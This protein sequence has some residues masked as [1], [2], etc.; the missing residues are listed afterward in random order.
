MKTA[1]KI[2]ASNKKTPAG[3]R[4]IFISALLLFFLSPLGFSQ[5]GNTD[6][7]K[8][9]AIFGDNMVL[10]RDKKVPVWG[11]ASP[12]ENIIVKINGQEKTAKADD[13]GNW[14]VWMEPSKAGGPY[15]MTVSNGKSNIEFK[16]VMYGD[17]WI[18][19]GQSN[20]AMT[21]NKCK[22]S[23]KEIAGANYPEIRSL[24]I[25]RFSSGS[26]DK[27]M[28]SSP[29]LVCSPET[30]SGFSGA[31]YFF[32]RDLYKELKI[33][34]GIINS[35]IGGTPAESWTAV[36]VLEADPDLAP[37][38]ERFKSAVAAYPENKKKFDAETERRK[39]LS[40]D[41]LKKLPKLTPPM[42]IGHLKAPC[43]L[44]NAMIYPLMPYA[45]K[46]AIW[47]QGEANSGRAYQYR[48]LLPAM[49]SDWRKKWGQGNF[50]FLIVQLASYRKPQETPAS[51]SWA[52]L[53]EAQT[54]TL[55][56]PETA[57]ALA[58]DIG[59]ANNIHPENKQG[60]GYRLSLAALKKAYGKDIV[61][62]GPAYKSMTVE[63]DKAR[64]K[65]DHIG[66]GLISKDGDL[67]RFS[68]AGADKNFV[69]ASAKIDGDTVI[70]WNENVKS[71]AAVRYAW[72]T[73]PEGCNLYNKEG[74]PAIPFRTD[75]WPGVTSQ[76][77]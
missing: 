74:L 6:S 12:G 32:A 50:P 67:K 55:S 24:T 8:P 41:E 57:L 39:Q 62:S 38:L 68:I 63:G 1:S 64:V 43:G 11:S 75:D 10:Q 36:E 5:A 61:Y 14:I 37:I 33:P 15:V 7:F 44:Y 22:E 70:V 45:I 2:R 29:W 27:N 31:A 17:V 73:N 59:D 4:K 9:H 47:Y 40:P 30:V 34:M 72:E 20:M 56:L 25:P 77:K 51:D 60:V 66:G 58:I 35:S 21:V 23:E 16:N 46:G 53:R 19:S 13:K 49:I 69:W 52:E 54:M 71:P 42:N 3:I 18:C 26:P 28:K 65:F 76:V 48:K